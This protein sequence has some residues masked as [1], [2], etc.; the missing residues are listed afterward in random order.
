MDFKPFVDKF[1]KDDDEKLGPLEKRIA[2]YIVKRGWRK[3]KILLIF[4]DLMIKSRSLSW[5][6]QL[7]VV[8]GR[9]AKFSLI[10]LSQRFF[11]SGSNE[12]MKRIN[13]NHDYT[14]YF[15]NPNNKREIVD[16]SNRLTPGTHE[17]KEIYTAI[18][19]AEGAYSYLMIDNTQEC[20]RRLRFRTNL[21][22]NDGIVD[23]Y[24]VR[25]E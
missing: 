9:H 23:V 8:L 19:K 18:T 4:D 14:V 7:F 10:F 22:K 12:N 11:S 17:V 2:A 3:K 25:E 24:V 20:D 21:F 5:I 1:I 6:S 16:L 13:T 15:N